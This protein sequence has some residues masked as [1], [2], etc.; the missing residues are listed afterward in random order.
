MKTE[1]FL[2]IDPFQMETVVEEE[3]EGVEV[4]T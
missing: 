4:S 3:K 2:T 1:G